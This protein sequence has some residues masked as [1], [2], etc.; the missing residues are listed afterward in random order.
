MI[1]LVTKEHIEEV[2]ALARKIKELEDPDKLRDEQIIGKH[3]TVLVDFDTG[4]G[5]TAEAM[6]NDYPDIYKMFL[7]SIS[8][9][10]IAEDVVLGGFE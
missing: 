1:E 8:L 6:A 7:N 5:I 9:H 4:L 2:K 3:G 10:R